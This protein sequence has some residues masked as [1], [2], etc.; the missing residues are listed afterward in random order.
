[1]TPSI[2]RADRVKLACQRIEDSVSVPPSRYVAF[3]TA[4]LHMAVRDWAATT[5]IAE[6]DEAFLFLFGP[7]GGQIFS[8]LGIDPEWMRGKLKIYMADEYR[9]ALN[10]G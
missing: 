1:M 5:F 3:M 10:A 4:F 9:N 6:P 2:S 7:R 8:L